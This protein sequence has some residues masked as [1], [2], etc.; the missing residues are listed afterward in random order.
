MTFRELCAAVRRG[1]AM[2]LVAVLLG[3]GVTA[4]WTATRT[5]E[6]VATAQL[7]LGV[8]TATEAEDSRQDT[9][10]LQQRMPSYA[11]V[12][13]SPALGE[14]V[15]EELGIAATGADV[16]RS[17]TVEVPDGTVLLDVAVRDS[18]AERAQAIANATGSEF[19]DYL[20]ELENAGGAE[21]DAVDVT[22]IRSAELPGSPASP[23]VVVNVLAGA[24][25][26]LAVGLGLAFLRAALDDRVRTTADVE[27]LGLRV[28]GEVPARGN[29]RSPLSAAREDGLRRVRWHLLSDG[30]HGKGLRIVT[31]VAPA[32]GCESGTMAMDLARSLVAAGESVIV[33]DADLTASCVAELLDLPRDRPGF[34]DLVTG[35]VQPEAVLVPDVPGLRVVPAGRTSRHPADVVLPEPT[36]RA[37]RALAQLADRVVVAGSP[38]DGTAEAEVVASANDGVVL[39]VAG[40][41]TRGAE[42]RGA[43]RALEELG[44]DLLGCTVERKRAR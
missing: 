42:A 18:S 36:D 24:L 21:I 44:V 3:V 4:A 8:R 32:A 9:L 11:A 25:L 29:G 13:R 33:V 28:L 1:W 38:L 14:R 34:A 12:L 10:Y 31:L 35:Q 6:Y 23:D 17:M 7:F 30:Q 37:L 27:A 19:A 15:A 20:A 39:L 41:R 26:G 2:V 43:A 22:T 5:P 40:G 16:A